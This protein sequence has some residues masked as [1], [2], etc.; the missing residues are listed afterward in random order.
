ML[1]EPTSSVRAFDKARRGLY[2][3]LKKEFGIPI[4]K[5]DGE[6]LE[7]LTSPEIIGFTQDYLDEALWHHANRRSKK[8]V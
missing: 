1:S 4:T 8:T 3:E 6:F 2:T 5:S 7:R